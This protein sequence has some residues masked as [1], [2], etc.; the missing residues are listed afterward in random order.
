MDW[1]VFISHAWE[2]K[3]DIARPLAE[4]LDERGCVSGTTSSL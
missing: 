4:A 2:D 3:E 1:D